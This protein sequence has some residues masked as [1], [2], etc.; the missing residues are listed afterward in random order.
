MIGHGFAF[1]G[2]RELAF[3]VFSKIHIYDK[4]LIVVWEDFMKWPYIQVSEVP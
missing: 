1:A 3:L 2:W 4:G